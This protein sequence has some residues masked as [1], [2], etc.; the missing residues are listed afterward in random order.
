MWQRG[1]ALR[2]C[3]TDSGSRQTETRQEGQT[4]HCVG[5]ECV[6]LEMY[7]SACMWVWPVG[8]RCGMLVMCVGDVCWW[9]WL[10]S[11]VCWWVWL[12]GDACW[13]VWL[14]SDACWWVWLVS[15]VLMGVAC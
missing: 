7:V 12:V 8:E 10:V 3:H 6:M 11:D 14:V 15:V 13:W 9:V 4:G 5:K 1:T 2:G